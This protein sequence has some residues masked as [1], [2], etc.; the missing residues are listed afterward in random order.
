MDGWRK[1][2]GEMPLLDLYPKHV[3]C[4]GEPLILISQP[5]NYQNIRVSKIWIALAY[6]CYCAILL[7][8]ADNSLIVSHLVY[9]LFI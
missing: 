5:G 4:S 3:C 1:V 9:A 2:E 6:Q 8:C 7:A